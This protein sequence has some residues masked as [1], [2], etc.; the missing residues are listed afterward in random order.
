MDAS[1]SIMVGTADHYAAFVA[2]CRQRIAELGITFATV[3]EICGFPDRYTAILLTGGRRMSVFSLFTLPRGLALLPMFG[4]DAGQLERLKDRSSWTP[5]RHRLP[6]RRRLG[7]GRKRK[8][9]DL[10]LVAPE[11]FRQGAPS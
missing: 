1:L 10:T 6:V 9:P 7:G 3:D 5:R 8:H 4:H 2:L 11:A